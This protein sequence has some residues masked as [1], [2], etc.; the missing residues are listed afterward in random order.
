MCQYWYN[1]FLGVII[2][3]MLVNRFKIQSNL[4]DAIVVYR[5]LP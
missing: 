5:M 2:I 1:I 4:C 3:A